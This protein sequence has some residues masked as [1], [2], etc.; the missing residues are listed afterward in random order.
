MKTV[1]LGTGGYFPTKQRHTACIML[2]EVGVVLDAGTGMCEIGNY[3]QTDYLHI[4][5][6]HA[7]LDHIVGLTY[8]LNLL[9]QQVLAKTTVYADAEKL[10]AIRD[11]LFAPAV[12][13]V[14]P[15]FTFQPFCQPLSL[16]LGGTL[17]CFPLVHPG[18]S[19]GFR[20]DW[21]GHSLAY[22]TDTTA[23]ADA[24]YLD[25]IRGVDL[26]LH[27][28]YFA[29]NRN[30]LANITGH[31]DLEAVAKLAAHVKPKQL[32]LVHID[33]NRTGEPP[34]DLT[35]ARHVFPSIEIGKDRD[36][37]TF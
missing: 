21:P 22:V 9:P 25:H 20:L 34:L 8:L 26:L 1:L 36:E 3:L 35:A 31:S 19:L 28:A 18:G 13:P 7:H 12:F 32:V 2:P 24:A 29:D 16:P 4:F 27:E 14:G 33:P 6:S 23:T 5:L 15:I 10:A 37:I 11:H 30:N 17:T